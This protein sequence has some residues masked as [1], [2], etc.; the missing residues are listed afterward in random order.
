MS[1]EPLWHVV[2]RAVSRPRFTGYL[3]ASNHNG[4]LALELYKWNTEISS[5]F[6]VQ[7]GHMEIA[8]R[9][10]ISNR[11]RLYSQKIHNEDDWISLAQQKEILARGEL[12]RLEE[13]KGRVASNKKEISFDQI[14]S[15]LPLGFWATLLGK[16]YRNIWPELAGGFLGLASRDSKE[17]A[18]LVQQARWLRNRIGHHHRIWNIDLKSHH[19]GILRITHMIDP[20]LERWLSSVSGVPEL[21]KHRPGDGSRG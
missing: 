1:Q 19:I 5:A 2:E 12:L 21:L 14:I 7:L 9:N 10:T 17:L 15:E 8:L 6:W 13:A 4:A 18:R 11:I 20:E 3:Q 16:R